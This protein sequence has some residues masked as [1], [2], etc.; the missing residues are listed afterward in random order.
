MVD[1]MCLWKKYAF[2]LYIMAHIAYSR[3]ANTTNK[4]MKQ[5]TNPP[6]TKSST[7]KDLHRNIEL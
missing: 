7:L 5:P 4:M 2:P 3:T 1:R 6:E